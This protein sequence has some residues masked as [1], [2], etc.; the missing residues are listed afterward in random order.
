MFPTTLFKLEIPTTLFDPEHVNTYFLFDIFV[1]LVSLT[2]CLTW[3][4]LYFFN[5]RVD[6]EI[7]IYSWPKWPLLRGRLHHPLLIVST[8]MR[9]FEFL[10]FWIT[11]HVTFPETWRT[12]SP[13][14]SQSSPNWI[15]NSFCSAADLASKQRIEIERQN[16]EIQKLKERLTLSQSNHETDRRR[17]EDETRV[18]DRLKETNAQLTQ[19]LEVS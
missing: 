11:I 13:R 12:N 6:T 17:L 4:C 3:S 1:S 7:H 14:Y 10:W 2:Y 19:D 16:A 5:L 9:I 8:K 18:A 15:H